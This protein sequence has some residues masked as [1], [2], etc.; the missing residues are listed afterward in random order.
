MSKHASNEGMSAAA[1]EG[2]KCV[3]VV[4]M[5]FPSKRK[6][7]CMAKDKRAAMKRLRVMSKL[8][9]GKEKQTVHG[10]PGIRSHTLQRKERVRLSASY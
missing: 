8:C 6:A 1:H 7:E 3:N 5:S 10:Q 2:G 4:I 9:F